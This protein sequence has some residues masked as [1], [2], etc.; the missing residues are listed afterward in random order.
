MPNQG[1]S[2]R[3]FASMDEDRQREI[4]GKGG[5]NA[6]DDERS[7]SKDRE[8]AAEAGRRGGE[9][10]PGGRHE[11]QGGDGRRDGDGHRGGGGNFAGD[12]ERAAEAGRKGGQH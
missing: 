1:T 8:L 3:G 5:Q 2:E 11:A 9:H 10:S 6:R 4:A 12:R 7:F